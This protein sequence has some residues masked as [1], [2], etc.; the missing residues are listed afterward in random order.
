M[1]VQCDYLPYVS[2][3]KGSTSCRPVGT[4]LGT[5]LKKDISKALKRSPT[6]SV[7]ER[8]VRLWEK[9]KDFDADYGLRL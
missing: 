5:R 2:T 9:I 1:C 3:S 4:W 8:H 7:N 6:L